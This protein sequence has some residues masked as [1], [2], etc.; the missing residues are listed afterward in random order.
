MPVFKLGSNWL[1]SDL[2]HV[3]LVRPRPHK[4]TALRGLG[5]PRSGAG[6]AS[7][8]RRSGSAVHCWLEWTVQDEAGALLS[9]SS[10][11]ETTDSLSVTSVCLKGGKVFVLFFGGVC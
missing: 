3:S 7:L 8:L 1:I 5:K 11:N 10:T 4:H 9:F 6:S 2:F